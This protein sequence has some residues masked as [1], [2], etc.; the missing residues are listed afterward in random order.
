M[1][2]SSIKNRIDEKIEEITQFLEEL[3][4]LIPAEIDLESYKKDLRTKA[5]C[6]RYV[7]KIIEAIEDLAFLIINIKKLN[8]PEIDKEVFDILSKNQIISEN[9]SQKFRDFKGMRNI[10]AHQYGKIDDEIVYTSIYEK[11]IEDDIN[12][13]IH[14]IEKIVDSK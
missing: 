6:E 8:Y 2:E 3:Y 14:N 10:I 12:E 4:T 7:E 1:E 11:E 13:F 5:I 9:L